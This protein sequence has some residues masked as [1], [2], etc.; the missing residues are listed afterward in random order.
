M[1]VY[2]CNKCG[3]VAEHNYM[4]GMDPVACKQCGNMVA[5][6]DTSFFVQK[7]LERY[8]ATVRELKALQTVEAEQEQSDSPETNHEQGSWL[9]EDIH[10]STALANAEQHKPIAIW[11]RHKT[12]KPYLIIARLT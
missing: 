6:Y 3:T 9:E 7:L 1:G 11:L 2:R 8:M 12:P 4:A 5:V 10:N